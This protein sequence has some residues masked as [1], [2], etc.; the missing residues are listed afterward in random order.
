MATVTVRINGMDYN[1]KGKEDEGYLKELAS[2]VEDKLQE[3]LSK[4]SKLSVSA[5]SILTAINL[6]DEAFKGQS[7]LNEIQSNYENLKIANRSFKK[8]LE[9]LLQKQD[10]II[11]NKEIEFAGIIKKLKFELENAIKAKQ[12]MELEKRAAQENKNILIEEKNKLIKE[13]E[14]LKAKVLKNNDDLFKAQIEKLNEELKIL[15]EENQSL[16]RE[17]HT[18]KNSNKDLK[19]NLQTSKYKLIDLEKKFI[20]SQILLAKE[21]AIKEPLKVKK[22]KK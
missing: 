18:M 8:E 10:L 4:N 17:N 15:K 9:E 3:I 2:Y 14:E 21:K 7:K 5:A 19:F 16:K 20:E 12:V 22:V 1:L 13:Q 6:A 11:K